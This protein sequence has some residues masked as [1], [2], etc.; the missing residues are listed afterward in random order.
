LASLLEG[1]KIKA[2]GN[3]LSFYKSYIPP[4]QRRFLGLV[5]RENRSL[6]LSAATV[7]IE[8]V[9]CII[10]AIF[11]RFNRQWKNRTLK[12]FTQAAW[13]HLSFQSV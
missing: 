8:G 7:N 3:S 9:N 6:T 13:H 2:Q 5:G 12:L 1:L 11:H 4:G 10:F